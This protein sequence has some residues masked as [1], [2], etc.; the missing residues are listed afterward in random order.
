M[1]IAYSLP[2]LQ[3]KAGTTLFPAT[4][5]QL[6]FESQLK[7]MGKTQHWFGKTYVCLEHLNETIKANRKSPVKQVARNILF[8][9][10]N[11]KILYNIIFIFFRSPD[12]VSQSEIPE[13]PTSLFEHFFKALGKSVLLEFSS[14]LLETHGETCLPFNCYVLT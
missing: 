11:N 3:G 14:N 10:T 13:Q 5:W 2:N 9:K 1:S 8:W 12:N 6:R 4:G 7:E